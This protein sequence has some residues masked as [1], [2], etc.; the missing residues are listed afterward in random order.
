MTQM[1]GRF[2]TIEGVEGVGKSTSVGMI[3]SILARHGITCLA[4]RE[5]GGTRLSEKIRALLLDRDDTSM[6]P[7]VELLLMFAARVQHVEESIKPALAQGTWVVCD[8]YTDSTYAYQGGGRQIDMQVIER[9]EQITLDN[10]RP[11]LTL[12]LDMPVAAGRKRAD[13]RSARDRFE[14]E[15]LAF[16]E[17]VRAVFLER[18]SLGERYHLIDAGGDEASVRAQIE[19]VIENEIRASRSH[20]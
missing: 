7:M 1:K 8:R 13:R 9:L 17:R 11:D 12:V 6:D 5:P 20:A 2:I 3:E 19:P 10:F 14:S 15:D 16:F 4:T 18:A